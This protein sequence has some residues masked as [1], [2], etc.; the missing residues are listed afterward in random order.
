MT[1]DVKTSSTRIVVPR[2]L[3]L[4]EAAL[5]LDVFA[6]L[7]IRRF[8]RIELTVSDGRLMDVEV[9]ERLDRKLFRAL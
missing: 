3:S 9:V 8:G 6:G 1:E 2:G 5:I 4:R 7:K